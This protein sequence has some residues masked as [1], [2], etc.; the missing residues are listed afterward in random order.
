MELEFAQVECIRTINHSVQTKN[1]KATLESILNPAASILCVEPT[2]ATLYLQLLFMSQQEKIATNQKSFELGLDEIQHKVNE[3][4]Q[5]AADASL[6]CVAIAAVNLAVENE[7]L[8]ELQDALQ[9]QYIG[10]PSVF[11]QYVKEYLKKF[12]ALKR[13]KETSVKKSN[14]DACDED[15]AWLEYQ[16]RSGNFYYFNMKTFESSWKKPKSYKPLCSYLT[17]SDIVKVVS[18]INSEYDHQTLFTSMKPL[19]THLQAHIRGFLVRQQLQR[20]MEYYHANENKIVQIQRWWRQCLKR[21]II[22]M[23][24]QEVKRI[25]PALV[26]IQAWVRMWLAQRRYLKTREHF[27]NHED[28]VRKIQTFWRANRT[29]RDFKELIHSPNPPL[30]IIKKFVHMLNVNESDYAEEVEFQEIRG[31]VVQ[32][33]RRNNELENEV[34][35]MDLKIGLLV[36]NRITLQEVISQGK[37]LKQWKK[38]NGSQGWEGPWIDTGKGL[39]ALSKESRSRLVAY[40]HLFYALQ[41]EPNYLAKLIFAMSPSRTTKFVESVILTLYNFGSTPREDYLL[42]HLFRTALEEEVHSKVDSP[43]DIV[44]GN[45]LVIRMVV[46]F[47]RNGRGQSCLREL[48][49]PLIKEVI[50]D[51]TL[52][53]NT[54]PI[55]VYKMWINEHETQTGQQS[56]L[57]YDV[58]QEEALSHEEVQK[59]FD[60]AIKSLQEKALIFCNTIVQSLDKIPY[61]MLYIAKVLYNCLIEKFPDTA[62]KDILKVVGNLLY[63]RYINSA[64]VAPDAFDIIDI[65]PDESLTN[66]QRRNL[67]SI[68]KVLQFAS[69]GK[70]FGH[71]TAHLMCLNPFLKRCHENFKNF[72]RQACTVEEPEEFF[73][74]DWYSE[75]TMLTQPTIYLSVQELCDTHQLLVEFE[76]QIAPNAADMLHELLEDVGKPPTIQTLVGENIEPTAVAHVAQ[77]EICLTLSSKFQILREDTIDTDQLF[78]KTKQMMVDLLQHQFQHSSLT[79]ILHC[80]ISQNDEIQFTK[81]Q[82]HVSELNVSV[83]LNKSTSSGYKRCSS[84]EDFRNSLVKNLYRL[85]LAGYVSSKNDYQDILN[86]I[87]KDIYSSRQYRQ[88]RKQEVLRLRNIQKQLDLKTSYYEEKLDYYH[89]YV[90]T[91]LSNLTWDKKLH[92]RR[93]VPGSGS[94]QKNEEKELRNKTS[95]KYNGAKLHEKGILVEITDLDPVQLKNVSFEI[96]PARDTGVFTVSA[97]F[98]GVQMEKVDVDIQDLLHYQYQGIAI[99][100]MFERARVNV[101]LL[102]YLL[103]SK[104]YGKKK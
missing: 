11:S 26:K 34:N 30:Y 71:D 16:V 67:G 103:N 87:A 59:R 98:M 84:F 62:E 95:L 51:K 80:P 74:M 45:P 52:H 72:F 69:L 93:A 23:H 39:K 53:I 81:R 36:R 76:E 66:E 47:N 40:Q 17:K 100:E 73:N 10:I 15:N 49:E 50:N 54:N 68:A 18:V 20:K 3:A 13:K 5:L 2:L 86:S 41:T 58:S 55:E 21:R 28:S 32:T 46:G 101:N 64:I 33:I 35:E 83:N 102:L 75:A 104:F 61:G 4:N 38:G 22:L 56:T 37:K 89:Q 96:A 6:S 94:K 99:M 8:D 85:E 48:L 57:P 79:E 29:K 90:K 1:E 82:H 63:Y 19:I 14:N 44:T 27:K 91:C 70:G 88:H 24:A 31:Q 43:M 9:N 78:I 60:K 92:Q 42:L 25:L 77:T 97:R 65:G 7:N 12:Q